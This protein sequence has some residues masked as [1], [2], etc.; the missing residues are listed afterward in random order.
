VES[1]QPQPRKLLKLHVEAILLKP[2][3]IKKPDAFGIRQQLQLL[4]MKELE[5]NVLTSTVLVTQ[6]KLIVLKS[7]LVSTTY[8]HGMLLPKLALK[9]LLF[10]RNVTH[11]LKTFNVQNHTVLGRLHL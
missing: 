10:K 5:L 9:K 7:L 11:S 8:V 6:Q 4:V 3:A 1:T 2:V